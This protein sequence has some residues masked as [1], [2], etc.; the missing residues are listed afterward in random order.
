MLKLAYFDDD[1]ELLKQFQDNLDRDF[2]VVIEDKAI[3]YPSVLERGP[4]DAIIIDLEM[5]LIDGFK[6]FEK[7]LLHADYNGCPIIFMTEDETDQTTLSALKLGAEDVIHRHWSPDIQAERIKQKVN[8]YMRDHIYQLA[9]LRIDK[10]RYK[11]TLDNRHIELSL[12]E[13]KL[14]CSLVSRYPRS[15][16]FSDVF[17]A[18]WGTEMDDKNLHTHLSNLRKKLKGWTLSFKTAGGRKIGI[19]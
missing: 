14:V 11:V 18:V 15:A 13:F 4:F 12:I 16:D 9:N 6:L 3:N 19:V 8:R 17:K 1:R 10:K 7:I 2:E 5:P